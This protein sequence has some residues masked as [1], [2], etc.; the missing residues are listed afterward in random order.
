MLLLNE[1]TN[2]RIHKYLTNQSINY[3]PR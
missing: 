1:L 3:Q 2:E